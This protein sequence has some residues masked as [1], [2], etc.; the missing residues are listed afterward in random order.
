MNIKL[1][2]INFSLSKCDKFQLPWLI[3]LM[4][5]FVCISF[6]LVDNEIFNYEV[7]SSTPSA[8][9]LTQGPQALVFILEDLQDKNENVS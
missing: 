4:L 9:W 6:V 3:L 1:D 5:I 8:A 7:R 2:N